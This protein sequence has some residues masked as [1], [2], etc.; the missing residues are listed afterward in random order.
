MNAPLRVIGTGFGRTGTD[1]MREALEI[2]GFGPCHHMRA[3][4]EDDPHNMAWRG[5]IASE[6]MDWDQL[7]G[8]Y[9]SC[10]DW[11]SAHYWPQLVEQFPEAK[12]L[13]TWRTPE[14]WWASFE[15]TILPRL[16]EDTETEET[17]PGSQLIALRVFGGKP[18]EKNHC[19]SAYEANVAAVKAKIPADRLLIYKI[20]DGWDPLCDFLNVGVPDTPYPRSNNTAE[21]QKWMAEDIK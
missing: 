3:L 10:V 7:L 4:I 21:F 19:I 13:L 6:D 14:S 11:P 18:L 5:C 16:L 1:S 15:K 20:G 9:Q 8:G 12:V 17:A 2:L